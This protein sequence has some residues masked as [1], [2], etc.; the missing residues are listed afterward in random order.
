VLRHPA[1]ASAFSLEGLPRIPRAALRNTRSLARVRSHLPEELLVSLKRLREVS[2]RLAR[3]S[4]VMH[5]RP[6]VCFGF[7]AHGER[8]RLTIEPALAVQLTVMALG[9]PGPTTLR[10]LGRSER[11]ALAGVVATFLHGAGARGSVR[12]ALEDP[13]PIQQKH[14][15]NIELHVAASSFSGACWLDLP[16]RALVV[17]SSAKLIVD[18]RVLTTLVVV[19]LGRTCLGAEAFASAEAG[20]TLVFDAMAALHGDASW[21]VQLRTGSCSFSA[22]LRPDGTLRRRGPLIRNESE[23][24]MSSDDANIT[25]PLPTMPMSDDAARALASAPIELVA[26]IGRLTI[27]GDELVGLVDG[28]VLALGPRRPAEVTLR[29]GGR[30]WARGELVAVDDELAVRITAL[31]R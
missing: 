19:E 5:E 18:S 27:R 15:V 20:D 9:L 17:P 22:E 28:A 14:A 21:P 6:G 2:V 26:E 7:E 23:T 29:A 1:R 10:A 25:A 30:A 24:E 3:V 11:G 8:G 4:F 16:S 12:V 13:G 31:I